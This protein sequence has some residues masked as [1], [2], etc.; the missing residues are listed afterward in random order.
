MKHI[1]DMLW[2]IAVI[3]IFSLGLVGLGLMIY[4]LGTFWG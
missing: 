4:F 3:S 2:C 1:Y